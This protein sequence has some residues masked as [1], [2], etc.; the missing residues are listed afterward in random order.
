MGVAS[1]HV[2]KPSELP[3]KIIIIESKTPCSVYVWKARTSDTQL[4]KRIHCDKSVGYYERLRILS[5]TTLETRGLRGDIIEVFKIF[6]D[7]EDVSYH[8]YF[9]LSQ[10]GL[11]GHSYKLDKPSFRHDIRTFSFSVRLINIW[12][13]LPYSVL[14]CN[15]VNTIKDY[16]LTFK[17]HLD[18]CLKKSGI[19]M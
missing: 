16:L 7:F 9:I 18:L 3:K 15:T 14:Q 19:Y 12:N 1:W 5:L 13:A 17:R 4:E 11:C 8:T 2:E 10:S 6:N